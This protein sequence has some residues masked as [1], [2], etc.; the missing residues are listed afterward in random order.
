MPGAGPPVG[1]GGQLSGGMAQP[2]VRARECELR[3]NVVSDSGMFAASLP[4]HPLCPRATVACRQDHSIEVMQRL[5]KPIATAAAVAAAAWPTL[6]AAQEQVSRVHAE[7]SPIRKVVIL[8]EDMK[9]QAE[10]DA[11]EDLKVHDKYMCWCETN[12]KQKTEASSDSERS[13]DLK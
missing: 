4:L 13:G 6:G 2:S 9:A 1:G 12:E 5:F 11:E 7:T 10:K 3:P 8:I